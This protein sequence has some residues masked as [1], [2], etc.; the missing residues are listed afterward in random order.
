MHV[1]ILS[2]L[3]GFS[4]KC[5]IRVLGWN[6][7]GSHNRRWARVREQVV[8]ANIQRYGI[9][10]LQEVP[11]ALTDIKKRFATPARY[12]VVMPK[13]KSSRSSCILYNPSTLEGVDDDTDTITETMK[14]VQGRAHREYSKRLCVKV[15]TL[16]GK[17][18]TTKFVAIS[19]HAPRRNTKHFC[20]VVKASIEKVVADHKLPVLV[21]GDFNTDIYGWKNEG[22]L[23]LHE[24]RHK[25]IDFIVMKVPRRNR[26]RIAKVQMREN[27][28][29]PR[30]TQ[31]L[32]VM[33]EGER[34]SVKKFKKQYTYKFYQ[35][36]CDSHM[37]LKAEISERE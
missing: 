20:D 27:V 31:K 6:I 26:L 25:R 10:F 5:I 17:R 33:R 11:W 35:G 28:V 14:S 30:K 4:H 29:I 16:K 21:G 22:F 24:A 7:M 32:E 36:L 19:L 15:F 34:T 37:P 23:G 2:C 13:E 1:L 8:L 3:T 9:V 12:D 18:R